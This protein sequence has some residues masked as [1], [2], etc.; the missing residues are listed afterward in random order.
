MRWTYQDLP[1]LTNEERLDLALEAKNEG[2]AYYQRATKEVEELSTN[3]EE[4][5][6][7]WRAEKIF[8]EFC[9]KSQ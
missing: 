8:S 6:Y 7:T 1:Q 9:I 4:Y 5:I 3:L 2:E